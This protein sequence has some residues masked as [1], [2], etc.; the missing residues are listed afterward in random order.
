MAKKPTQNDVAKLAGV[1]RGTVSIVLNNRLDGRVPISEE[2]RERVFKAAQAL[3]YAPNPVAQML[4]EGSN[5]LIGVF[6]YEA[7]FPYETGTFFFP[8]LL[9]IEKAASDQ[10][11][12]VLF[13]TRN[14]KNA[15]P[16]IY[17][18]GM[19]SL[20][21]ADGTIILGGAPDRDELLRLVEEDY[22]F[23]CIGRREVPGC[24][25][26]W[27]TYGYETGSQEATQYLIDLGHTSLGFVYDSTLSIAEPTQDKLRGVRK[28][29]D[30]TNVQLIVLDVPHHNALIE[31]IHQ[32]QIT[33]LIFA[34]PT[35][36][37]SAFHLLRENNIAIPGD[38]SLLSLVN[39][40]EQLAYGVEPTHVETDRYVVAELAVR[41]LIQLLDGSVQPPQQHTVACRF[42]IGNT[43]GKPGRL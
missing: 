2:T 41:T 43:T 39:I 35:D 7:T 34:D 33:A 24:Q 32:H 11:Y 40:D 9:G 15:A 5:R 29:V 12:N 27:V 38:L 4:K 20:L 3:G 31:R 26:N 22:P 23:V 10:D 42:T 6:A 36:F 37:V 17:T 21:L 18:N 16:K 28:A 13:F 8:H 30:A 14:R 19:N 1:S 25:V